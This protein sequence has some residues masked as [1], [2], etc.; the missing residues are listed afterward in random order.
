MSL[1]A[2]MLGMDQ[3]QTLARTAQENRYN[4]MLAPLLAQQDYAGAAQL[5][6][7]RGRAQEAMSFAQAGEK[8]QTQFSEAQRAE[9]ERE[10]QTVTARYTA[11]GRVM[12]ALERVPE[13]QRPQFVQQVLPQLAATGVQIDPNMIRPEMLTD[14]GVQMLKSQLQALG[15][16]IEDARQEYNFVNVGGTL[17]KTD[18]S[19]GTAMPV[20][21]A[22]QTIDAP[23]G[24]RLTPD[25]NFAFIPGGPADPAVMAAQA[26]AKPSSVPNINVYTGEVTP[27]NQ[28]AA[29]STFM[30]QGGLVQRLNDIQRQFDEGA[31]QFLTLGG[32]L[33]TAATGVVDFVAPGFVA[34]QDRERLA[35]A[36]Q[37]KSSVMANF[38]QTLRDMSGAAVTQ[39]EFERIKGQMPSVDDGPTVFEAKMTASLALAYAAMQ[40]Q[41]FFLQQGIPFNEQAARQVPLEQFLA[42]QAP[43]QLGTPTG[44]GAAGVSGRPSFRYNPRT[45][46][47]E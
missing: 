26:L 39:N 4:S 32:R 8:R 2:L 23:S 45:G 5:A 41:Q 28:T 36:A 3:G 35:Q 33:Q 21:T 14:Q 31:S 29:Q 20:F 30:E 34:P 47:L 18:P 6:G 22:P 40:R 27:S 25:G 1:N 19:Q 7:Q 13:N 43:Q 9:A 44:Q 12:T 37:F 42:G 16:G 17:I 38:N 10:M 46:E 24:Y 11:L 15:A